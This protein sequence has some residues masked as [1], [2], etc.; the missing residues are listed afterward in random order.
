MAMY[1]GWGQEEEKQPPP[2]GMVEPPGFEDLNAINGKGKGKGKGDGGKG[3]YNGWNNRGGYGNYGATKGGGKGGWKG[4]GKGKGAFPGQCHYCQKW[5][6]RL[7]Q[8]EQKTRDMDRT[9][10][11]A[12][13]VEE[14]GEEEEDEEMCILCEDCE[15]VNHVG[16]EHDGW[17]KH[18]VMMDSGSSSSFLAHSALPGVEV[19]GPSAKD[20][21]RRWSTASGDE[22]RMTGTS[23]VKFMTNQGRRKAQTFKRSNKIEKNL[24]AVSEYCDNDQ[25]VI[26]SKNGGAIIKDPAEAFARWIVSSSPGAVPFRRD[27]GKGTYSLDMWVPR[28]EASR[29]QPARREPQRRSETQTPTEEREK[30]NEDDDCDMEVDQLEVVRAQDWAE[31]VSNKQKKKGA[32][33]LPGSGNGSVFPR[34]GW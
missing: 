10:G 16:E 18:T 12:Y 8:C 2:Q 26:F 27:K 3:V 34:P 31:F 14:D 25:L 11:K 19:K 28:N 32:L 7:N 30:K 5:G 24:A 20:A 13:A 17:E 9:R 29:G 21:S 33:R 22:V 4:G 23:K 6:H 15:E 1:G